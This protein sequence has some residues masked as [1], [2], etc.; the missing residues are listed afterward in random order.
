MPFS[1]SARRLAA[2]SA[3]VMPALLATTVSAQAPIRV[4]G[5][6]QGPKQIVRVDPV[7][8][9]IAKQ[10]K[11]EGQV[12]VE[13]TIARDGTVKDIRVLRGN[14]L[15]NEAAIEAVKQWKYETTFV[16]GA[17]VD[18]LVTTVVNFT[19]KGAPP[20]NVNALLDQAKSARDA[21]RLA[22]VEQLLQRALDQI[23][24]ERS[25]QQTAASPAPTT[26]GPLRI[27][28]AV[29]APRR[30][31][32]VEPTYPAEASSARVEGQTI[33]E[34]VLGVDGKVKSTRVLRSLPI[35]EQ[36]AR[37]AVS[38]WVYEPTTL[39]GVP[40]EIVMTVVVNFILK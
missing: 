30:I 39:N 17:A 40:V 5:D 36:A 24:I 8:P 14:A 12:I 25:D 29:N 21:G 37:D 9:P 18:V 10:A 4:G 35:F 15:F 7:Y 2:L 26:G 1:F 33:L 23:R 19:L 16:N 6:I 32:Y 31:T 28:G 3:A 11:V 13:A 38:Q 20:A 34:V 22:E 27:G